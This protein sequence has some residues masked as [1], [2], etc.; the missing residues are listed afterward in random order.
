MLERKNNLLKKFTLFF[1]FCMPIFDT[2]WFYSKW[3]TAVRVGIIFLIFIFTLI[4]YK[5]SRKKSLFLWSWY[6]LCG[7]YFIINYYHSFDFFALQPNF[8]NYSGYQEL[9]TILK[10]MC[11]PT[12][13]FSLYYQKFNKKEYLFIIKSW[14][15]IIAGS[16]ILTNLFKISL[17][18]YGTNVISYNIF[19]WN[20]GLYYIKTASRGFFIYA[21][22]VALIMVMLLVIA[23]YMTA[24]VNLKNIIYLILLSL[25]MLMLGT[26]VSSLGGLLILMLLFLSYFVYQIYKKEKINWQILFI[27]IPI[28]VWGLLLFTVSPYQN[29]NV[30]L[31]QV[32][33]IDAHEDMIN[34]SKL[35]NALIKHDIKETK[36]K[37]SYV[38]T[39]V[40]NNKLPKKF[41]QSYY[42]YV[43]DPDFWYDFVLNTPN[44]KINYRYIETSIIKRVVQIDDRTSDI[45]FGISNTRIQNIVNIERDFLLHYYAFGI[46]GC[47]ILLCIYPILLVSNFITLIK[48]KDYLSFICLINIVLF[49]SIAY[50]TG[51]ILNSINMLIYFAFIMAIK[52]QKGS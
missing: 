10:L 46:V 34:S 49:T 52:F 42:S 7:I 5:Q 44:E 17:S 35:E 32:N 16:I 18:S 22:Q 8:S 12:L 14:V 6:L 48:K 1:L 25:A 30:E 3:T 19:E 38:D 28:L 9:L 31:D 4:F 37:I 26:R 39:Y 47:I 41:Y 40:D 20:K 24:F 29:R 21:N 45:W 15:I 36:D 51:N 2:I 13:L 23:F 50:L 27:L 11:L 33:E 43:Y